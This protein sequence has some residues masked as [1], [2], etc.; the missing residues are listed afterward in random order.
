MDNVEFLKGQNKAIVRVNPRI[1]PLEVVF[2]AA[3]AMVDRAYLIVN[4]DPEKEL[5]ITVKGREGEKVEKV[6]D[7]FFNQLLNYSVYILQAARNQPVREAIITRALETN[8]GVLSR[9][10]EAL[11]EKARELKIGEKQHEIEEDEKSLLIKDEK[12]IAEPWNP[13]MAKGLKKP[14]F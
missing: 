5:E 10:D 12:G 13:K 7:D 11:E 14:D 4:G 1:F 2:C 3:Y 9:N 8:I 6:T